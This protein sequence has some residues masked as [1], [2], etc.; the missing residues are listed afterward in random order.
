MS[1]RAYIAL[2]SNLGDRQRYFERALQALRP[3]PGLVV[4]RASAYHET[5]PVGGPPGQRPY[6]N[7]TAELET[8]LD[9]AALLQTLLHV[10]RTLGRVRGELHGPRTIDLDLLLYGD[11]IRDQPDPIIPH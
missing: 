11:L 5:A 7:A 6:L 9:P 1:V 8:A 3:T 4:I 10:E 2:G